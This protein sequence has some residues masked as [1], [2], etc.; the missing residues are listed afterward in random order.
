M[1][2]PF[3]RPVAQCCTMLDDVAWSLIWFKLPMQHCPTFLLFSWS[4]RTKHPFERLCPTMLHSRTR[5]HCWIAEYSSNNYRIIAAA[6][7]LYYSINNTVAS[8]WQL[9]MH[10]GL[11]ESHN[12]SGI[13]CCVQCCVHVWTPHAT[14][15]NI[16][17][18]QCW[19][20]LHRL[21]RPLYTKPL[22]IFLPNLHKN[23]IVI[24]L[25][26]LP[27]ISV[28]FLPPWPVLPDGC[29]YFPISNS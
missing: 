8:F 4:T 25:A 23:W 12:N 26:V 3:E 20:M 9:A 11:L 5:T 14:S 2:H 6:R 27:N 13:Q 1:L 10:C 7:H 18:Q 19:M 28:W 29:I 17:D 22:K 16:V 21:N 15:S 24:C